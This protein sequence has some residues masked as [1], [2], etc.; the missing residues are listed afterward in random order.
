MP[1]TLEFPE[2]ITPTK[3]DADLAVE[4]S[5]RLA[6]FSGSSRAKSKTKPRVTLSVQSNGHAED[7][8]PIP[9]PAFQL[10]TEILT[11]MAKGNAVTFIPIHAELTTQQAAKIL[12]V[13]RPFLIGLIDSGKQRCNMVGRHRRIKFEDLIN[14]KRSIDEER[15]RVLDELASEAQEL[16]PDY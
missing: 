14:F 6:Q 9:L 4:S 5:R 12:N 11:E 7:L 8:V 3:E 1:A 15:H 13:S 10:L 16:N 2:T